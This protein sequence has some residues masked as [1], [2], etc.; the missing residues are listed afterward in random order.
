MD[1]LFKKKEL[2]KYNIYDKYYYWQN[3]LHY[4]LF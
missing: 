2:I 3:I 4:L 1:Y